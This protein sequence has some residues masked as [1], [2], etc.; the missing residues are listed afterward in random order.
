MNFQEFDSDSYANDPKKGSDRPR[1]MN[2]HK[3]HNLSSNEHQKTKSKSKIADHA[4]DCNVAIE[5]SV[6]DGEC[7]KQADN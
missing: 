4:K 2:G 1:E 6:S 7:P 5:G 3:M